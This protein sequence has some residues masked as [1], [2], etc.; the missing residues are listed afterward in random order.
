MK[1]KKLKIHNWRSI[2]DIDIDFQDLMVFI[3]QNN[4]GKSNVLSAILFFFGHINCSDLDFNSKND[5]IFIEITFSDLDTHDTTQFKK[6]VTR[7][8]TIKVR[9]EMPVG[10][11]WQYHGY[12]QIP[13]DDWLREESISNYTTRDAAKG[14]P[15]SVYLPPSGRIT[16]ES[17]LNAQ[18]EYIE[19]NHNSIRFNYNLEEGFF[20]GAKSVS[21]GIFGDLFFIPAVKNAS[22]EL[23]SKGKS[24]FNQLLTNVINKMSL[25]N[26]EY[27]AVK[28]K[29]KKLTETLNKN[30]VDGTINKKRPKQ[31]SELEK[32]LEEELSIW[33]TKINIEITPPDIDETLRLGTSVWVDDGVSTDINRKGHGL[34]RSLIFALVKSWA[35]LSNNN[36][37]DT[38]LSG[39]VRKASKSTY[40]IFEE[41]ELY[42][43]PQAQRDLYSSLKKLSEGQSQVLISTHSSS[44]VDLE[45]YKS[46]C[47]LHKNSIE[48]GTR[49]LQCTTELFEGV[50]EKKQFNL[51]YWLNP[52]R[53][54]LFFAKKIILVEGPTE[55]TVIPYL[56]KKK[57]IFRYDYTLIDCGGKSKI[58]LYMH[59]L[60]NFKLPY[61]AVY[62]KD[63]QSTKDPNAIAAADKDTELIEAKIDSNYGKSIVFE[64][65]IEE[66]LGFTDGSKKNKPYIALELISNSDFEIPHK[67]AE[68]LI[69]I[70]E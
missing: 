43:H 41:P 19:N 49:H 55:K 67:L 30:L 28:E 33:K 38:V 54:E 66:E 21:Q 26:S 48:E 40:F 64:N 31:L 25:D 61:I 1:I 20:L 45:T 44:F 57:N 46:I 51:T 63:H 37:D 42:L 70:Y 4:H 16:K 56:A 27:I 22:D 15:L 34:Q 7:E 9:K 53:G 52:D 69:L 23:N 12:R 59:L 39:T 11:S 47:I 5:N 68:K 3:G 10:G 17:F 18:N 13:E 35:K 60:N 32:S 14:L 58:P 36:L 24:I 6:Y 65:D 29:I 62:D 2:K 50:D 8:N